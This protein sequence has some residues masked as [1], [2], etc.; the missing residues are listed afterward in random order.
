MADGV[1]LERETQLVPSDDGACIFNN[2][3]I[4]EILSWVPGKSLL[5]CR[6]VCKSWCTLISDP[7][8]VR[9]QRSQAVKH[10]TNLRLLMFTNRRHIRI[11]SIDYESLLSFLTKNKHENISR[12]V[13]PRCRRHKLPLTQ[14]DNRNMRI[15][16]S[17]NGLVCLFINC[18]YTLL[19]NPC[20]GN[21]KE[22]PKPSPEPFLPAFYGFGYDSA[23]DDYK[24]ICN[25]P[26]ADRTYEVFVF[27]LK[28]GSW[29]IVEGLDHI[30]DERGLLL[31]GALHWLNVKRRADGSI[32]PKSITITSFDLAKEKFQELVSLPNVLGDIFLGADLG[33]YKSSHLLCSFDNFRFGNTEIWV[34]MEYGVEQ[35]WTKLIVLKDQ[36]LSHP[37]YVS[38][39]DKVFIALREGD[40]KLYD[41]KEN[42]YRSVLKP[43]KQLRLAF[44]LY[45]ETLVSPATG[46]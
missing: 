30:E 46:N 20:T 11:K 26:S 43:K 10:S 13:V 19:W 7:N 31:N 33:V 34:M 38:E 24:V 25:C 39:D 21:S 15:M 29:R 18:H 5:R 45:V 27:T 41:L 32:D 16:G 40:L 9:K 36:D 42:R 23:T 1:L 35:S 12:V 28:T 37:V 2:D 17:S 22:I 3:I 8:F 14:P 44:A 4:L 6:R